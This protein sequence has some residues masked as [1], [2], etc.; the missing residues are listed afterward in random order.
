MY[1]DKAYLFEGMHEETLKKILES[2]IEES[3]AQGDLLFHQDEPA[4]NF[5]ILSEGRVRISVGPQG[6]LAHVSSDPGDV[7][8]WSS[9]VGNETYTASAECLGPVKVSKI[10]KSQLDEI[11]HQ[12]PESGMTFFKHLAALIGRRL[13]DSYRATSAAHGTHEPRSYG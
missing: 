11:L 5:Y 7:I 8:G 12:D 6:L 4:R 9:L 1:I 13:V 3:H 2:A 10:E